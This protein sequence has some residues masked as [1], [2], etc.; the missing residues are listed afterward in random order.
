[1][2]FAFNFE[3]DFSDNEREAATVDAFNNPL[4]VVQID[5]KRLPKVEDIGILLKTLVGHRVSYSPS[6]IGEATVYRRELYDVKHQLMLEDDSQDKEEFDILIGDTPEDL[7]NGIYE[8]GLKSWECSFDTIERLNQMN[9]SLLF[10]NKSE[11]PHNILE[12]GCGTAL[13]SCHLF[14]RL[15]HEKPREKPVSLI[16]SDYNAS[17]LRLVT[18]PNLLINWALTLDSNVRE[19]LQRK[20]PDEEPV[21]R[22]EE[23]EVT[24]A[25]TDSF[26]NALLSNNISVQLVSGSWG[27]QFLDVLDVQYSGS[28]LIISSETIYSPQT[29]P[30]VAETILELLHKIRNKESCCALVAAKEIYFGVGGSVGEFL[31]YLE[32]RLH[33]T[34]GPYTDVVYDVQTINANLKRCI[35]FI[36]DSS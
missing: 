13:P 6:S 29:L 36:Q 4:D 2:S 21:I 33:V 30:I 26:V 10:G 3:E 11:E 22:D 18:L 27:R 12:L 20:T 15:F 16:L 8:G 24:Q 23:L 25:L 34:M 35:V 14:P 7:R 28:G 9:D 5:P 1:M 19:E 32:D 17:V 31:R